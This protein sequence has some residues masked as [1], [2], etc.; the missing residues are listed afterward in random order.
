MDG[1]PAG[2]VVIGAACPVGLVQPAPVSVAGVTPA[3]G[4]PAAAQLGGTDI[5]ASDAASP[6]LAATGAPATA[7]AGN[8]GAA[9]RPNGG[10]SAIAGFQLTEP[11]RNCPWP[12]AMKSDAAA[13]TFWK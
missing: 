4:T 1:T 12:S 2:T 9:A 7:G 3:A 10:R 6:T 8:S 13:P 5:P 11:G